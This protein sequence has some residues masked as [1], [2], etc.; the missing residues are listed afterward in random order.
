MW[1]NS[2]A[3][4]CLV[5]FYI[6]TLQASFIPLPPHWEY[7]KDD[8]LVPP[9]E[10]LLYSQIPFYTTGLTTTP[11]IVESI[12]VRWHTL[13][14]VMDR[15]IYCRSCVRCVTSTLWLDW[16]ITL[17]DWHTPSGSSIL[18]SGKS[19]NWVIEKVWD[20]SSFVFQKR[21][22]SEFDL[23]AKYNFENMNWL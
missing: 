19:W 17:R 3:H 8:V 7:T 9:A 20:P 11:T 13:V 18:R 5:K 15:N 10:P 21:S 14:T 22:F 16:I 6:L 2:E 4:M 12:K 1:S 23:L